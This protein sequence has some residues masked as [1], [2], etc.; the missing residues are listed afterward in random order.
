MASPRRSFLRRWQRSRFVTMRSQRLFY[1]LILGFAVGLFAFSTAY[2]VVNSVFLYR[3]K[4][5]GEVDESGVA[6][7]LIAWYTALIGVAGFVYSAIKQR[8]SA[9]RDHHERTESALRLLHEALSGALKTHAQ[10]F[11]DFSSFLHGLDNVY[12]VKYCELAIYLDTWQ[13]YDLPRP[14]SP[15]ALTMDKLAV[16]FLERTQITPQLSLYNFDNLIGRCRAEFAVAVTEF[17]QIISEGLPKDDVSYGRLSALK[18]DLYLLREAWHK[19]ALLLF[20][21]DT[22]TA[23]EQET[24]K[25]WLKACQ[26]GIH[27]LR[28][29]LTATGTRS[30]VDDTRIT[31]ALQALSRFLPYY[32]ALTAL[33]RHIRAYWYEDIKCCDV[34]VPAVPF[35]NVSRLYVRSIRPKEPAAVGWSRSPELERYKS[36][37]LDPGAS[38]AAPAADGGCAELVESALAALTA[39]EAAVLSCRSLYTVATDLSSSEI[40]GFI[41]SSSLSELAHLC[42]TISEVKLEF[43]SLVRRVHSPAAFAELATKFR[44]FQSLVTIDPR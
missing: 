2:F 15:P 10:N 41:K 16:A 38:S 17:D 14:S 40:D 21:L 23:F 28:V 19:V 29:D 6:S 5:I 37:R 33:Q 34:P 11:T 3:D 39:I 20:G 43:D 1:W 27:V 30:V 35:E 32:S 44:Y 36:T 24:L 12:M 8:A 26:D 4:A 13:Q 18:A 31:K 22:G 42:E 25:R 7:N 9:E